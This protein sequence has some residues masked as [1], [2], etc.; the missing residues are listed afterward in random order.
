LS[1]QRLLK[2]P[3]FDQTT[4]EVVLCS[5]PGQVGALAAG[6]AIDSLLGMVRVIFLSGAASPVTVNSQGPRARA[7]PRL[8]AHPAAVLGHLWA[9]RAWRCEY[10]YRLRTGACTKDLTTVTMQLPTDVDVVGVP[11]CR[12]R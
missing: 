4:P 11:G 5:K 6:M 2:F 3:F 10:R 7:S 1:F 12:G 8:G 9:D